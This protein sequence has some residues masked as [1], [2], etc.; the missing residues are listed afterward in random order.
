MLGWNRCASALCE[1]LH[2][3]RFSVALSTVLLGGY[4]T[5]AQRRLKREW[6]RVQRSTKVSLDC[7]WMLPHENDAL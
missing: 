7:G 2:A 6:S 1:A 4:P 3:V 5:A